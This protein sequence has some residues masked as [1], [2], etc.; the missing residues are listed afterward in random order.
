M[1]RKHLKISK[2]VLIVSQLQPSI[3][4]V[5]KFNI[6][7]T[8]F[9]KQINNIGHDYLFNKLFEEEFKYDDL[10]ASYKLGK[11]DISKFIEN[12]EYCI[13]LCQKLL[14]HDLTKS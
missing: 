9:A 8:E 1:S 4:E 6:V 2:N 10:S 5:E 14:E 13:E 11:L 7:E 12:R 3:K